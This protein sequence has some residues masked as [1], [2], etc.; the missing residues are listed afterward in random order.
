M[1][2]PSLRFLHS[3][4]PNVRDAHRT[5]YA[6]HGDVILGDYRSRANRLGAEGLY[7]I[8]N[9]LAQCRLHLRFGIDTLLQSTTFVDENG[10]Q[11]PLEPSLLDIEDD[12]T[13]ELICIYMR[14]YSWAYS[15]AQKYSLGL[16]KTR[17]LECQKRIKAVREGKNTNPK[18]L[19]TECQTWP[20][21]P[22][23]EVAASPMD[24]Q[25]DRVIGRRSNGAKVCCLF[26]TLS[27]TH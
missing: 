2:T 14:Y 7:A 11:Q 9:Y 16:T 24:P 10:Q 26:Y 12:D 13:W 8:K 15:Q 17:F 5:Y 22:R 4:P 23:I 1:Y 6:T 27:I 25:I 18:H 19:P 20:E 3:P 21:L